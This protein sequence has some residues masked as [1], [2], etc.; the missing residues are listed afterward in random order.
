MED[1][2][3]IA[4]Y[5]CQRYRQEYGEHIDEMKLHK[6]LYF[7]QR[8]SLIQKGAPLFACQFE[9]WKYGPVMVEIRQLYRHNLLNDQLNAD[10]VAEYK[11]VFD[12]VFEVY[13]PKDSWSLSSLTHGE[14]SWR[15]ARKGVAPDGHCS[16]K[17]SV[18]DIMQ[19]AERIKTRRFLLRRMDEVIKSTKAS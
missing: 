16:V 11:D 14:Y 15:E 19:D 1:V 6:L 2:R 9:A 12:K 10:A 18:D 7:I 8:E 4:S 17:M 5:V 3:T 13:A